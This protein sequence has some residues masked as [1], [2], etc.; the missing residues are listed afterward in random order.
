MKKFRKKINLCFLYT[1]SLRTLF[2]SGRSDASAII[3]NTFLR[4]SL[5]NTSHVICVSN[6]GKE[7]T[8]LRSVS[9]TVLRSVS[10]TVL[11]SVS[12]AV[13]RSVSFTVLRSV[14]FTVLSSV[15]FTVL[16]SVSFTVLRSV[17]ITDT[18]S[19]HL[20]LLS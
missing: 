19:G 5:A 1:F 6:T 13:L 8:V 16:R 10:F 15:S 17:S 7:N 11:R 18:V 14:S 12:F 9:F 4:Y 20:H 3:T 2:F